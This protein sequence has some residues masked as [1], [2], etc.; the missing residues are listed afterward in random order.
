[1][2]NLQRKDCGMSAWGE[3]RQRIKAAAD[4]NEKA[5]AEAAPSRSDFQQMVS[6]LPDLSAEQRAAL[7]DEAFKDMSDSRWKKR[8]RLARRQAVQA[9]RNASRVPNPKLVEMNEKARQCAKEVADAFSAAVEKFPGK[10]AVVEDVST[11]RTE[12][13]EPVLGICGDARAV[14]NVFAAHLRATL[15]HDPG[16]RAFFGDGPEAEA[17]M[18]AMVFRALPSV[19]VVVAALAGERAK[20][21]SAA[22]SA[23]AASPLP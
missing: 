8:R 3:L 22:N 15:W 10:T 6:R 23:K 21:V 18:G 13:A 9:E 14:I 19:E 5:L 17:R 4:T 12:P 1:M 11:H 2:A 16:M 7:V 20:G